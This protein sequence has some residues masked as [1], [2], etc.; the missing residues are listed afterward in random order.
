MITLQRHTEPTILYHLTTKSCIENIKL[1]GLNPS[2]FGDLI[3]NNNNGRGVYAIRNLENHEEL[4]K[5]MLLNNRT[6]YAV[7]FKTMFPWYECI[8][9]DSKV[10]RLGY[11][12]IPNKYISKNDIISIT[13]INFDDYF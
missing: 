5:N 12:V 13:K 11:V 9:N 10:N 7:Q 8:K 3:I 6:L 2:P 1:V 4:I